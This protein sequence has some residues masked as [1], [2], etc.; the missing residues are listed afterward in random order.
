MVESG[1]DEERVRGGGVGTLVELLRR[2][3]SDGHQGND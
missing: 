2:H 1:S 3:Q